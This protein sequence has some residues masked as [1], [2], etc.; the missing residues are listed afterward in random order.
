MLVLITC[1]C[2]NYMFDKPTG[3]RQL[4]T[5][6]HFIHSLLMHTQTRALTSTHTHAI[7]H[8]NIRTYRKYARAHTGHTHAHTHTRTHKM[9]TNTRTHANTHAL[10]YLRTRTHILDA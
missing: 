2:T 9:H 4:V 8:S 1:V 10:I 7:T 6:K 3:C 5:V